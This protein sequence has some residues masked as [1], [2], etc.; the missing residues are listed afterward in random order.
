[1]RTK[2]IYG[3]IEERFWP[4]VNVRGDDECWPWLAATWLGYGH[5]MVNRKPKKAHRI[6][7]ELAHG[8]IPDGLFVCHRCDNP[9]CVNPAHLFLGTHAD[10]MADAA[11]KG[12]TMSGD[13]HWVRKHPELA[14][15][16]RR[17]TRGACRLVDAQVLE[18]RRRRANGE[19]VVPLGQAFG[20]SHATI[21]DICRR[22]TW[23]HL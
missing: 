6:S 5:L 4:K 12:R 7:W 16:G 9:P 13:D 8:P 11:A 2:R 1:V 3:T 23:R 22:R 21:S 18:I 19:G 20:V 15:G 17:T 10:N 14:W